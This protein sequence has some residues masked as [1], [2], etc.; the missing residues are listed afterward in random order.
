MHTVP[1]NEDRLDTVDGVFP[2]NPL[3]F[4]SRSDVVARPVAI[5]HA[6]VRLHEPNDVEELLGKVGGGWRQTYG[7]LFRPVEMRRPSIESD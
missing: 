7:M 2:K 6:L 3:V 4:A 5:E 1:G